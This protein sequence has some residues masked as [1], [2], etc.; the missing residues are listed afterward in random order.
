LAKIEVLKEIP[1]PQGE[2]NLLAD[3]VI[4]AGNEANGKKMKSPL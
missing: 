2:D 3:A 4:I 1:L